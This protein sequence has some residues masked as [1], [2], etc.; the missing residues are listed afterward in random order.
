[1]FGLRVGNH[2]DLENERDHIQKDWL[3]ADPQ[4]EVWLCDCCRR[5]FKPSSLCL[6]D[7]AHG[8][9]V[10]DGEQGG[11]GHILGAHGRKLVLPPRIQ[12]K[13]GSVRS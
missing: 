8:W 11:V 2:T 6:L 12:G 10:K 1:M 7:N 13:A 3:G 4:K 9:E 5:T